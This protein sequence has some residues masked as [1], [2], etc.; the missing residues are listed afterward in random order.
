MIELIALNSRQFNNQT[1]DLGPE[2]LSD[3]VDVSTC[4]G[5]LLRLEVES[6]NPGASI[7]LNYQLHNG[8]IFM[9]GSTTEIIEANR[10]EISIG[11]SDMDNSTTITASV[12]F[13]GRS[14][15]NAILYSMAKGEDIPEWL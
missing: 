1:F 11:R 2:L 13:T 3:H 14:R 10:Y 5:L 7:T 8:A 12:V 9:G 15:I 6:M 4:G